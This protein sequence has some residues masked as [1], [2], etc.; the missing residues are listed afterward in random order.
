MAAVKRFDDDQ[1]SCDI[2]T[3]TFRIRSMLIDW[4]SVSLNAGCIISGKE[5]PASF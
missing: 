2:Q 4:E 3:D 1:F 5:P